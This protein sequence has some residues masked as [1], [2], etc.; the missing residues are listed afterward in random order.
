MDPEI[1]KGFEPSN[2]V[3]YSD[4]EFRLW[5]N[6]SIV[7]EG[8]VDL[9]IIR[10]LDSHEFVLVVILIEIFEEGNVLVPSNF[11]PF[12]VKHKDRSVLAY[13]IVHERRSSRFGETHD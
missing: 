11:T 9:Q 1:V 12:V 4:N 5:K 2:R 10:A 3:A 8:I 13:Q 7:L 6:R